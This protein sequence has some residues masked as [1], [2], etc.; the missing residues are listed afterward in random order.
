M[1]M[2]T[3]IV[4]LVYCQALGAFIG[5]SL[6][7]WGELAYVRAMRNGNID[8]AERVHLDALAR[9]LRFGM[10]L[11]LIASLGLVIAH[12][13]SRAVS[14]PALSDSYWISIVLALLIT[15]VS[16]ALSRRRVSFAFGSALL[17]TAWW[18]LAYLTVGL[19][20][21]LSFGAAVALFVVAV[22]VFHFL[23]RIAR[24]FALRKG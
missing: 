14:Q 23:L 18:F 19:L 24:S 22:A 17:F 12:F 3:L 1:T 4:F 13:A 11:L 7:I 20:P 16:W 2:T 21:P 15:G 9:G 8:A 10:T 5:A 6:A